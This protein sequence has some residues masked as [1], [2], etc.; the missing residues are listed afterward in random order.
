ME[1]RG[2]HYN[3]TFLKSVILRLDY[4][5][6]AVLQTDQETPFTQDMKVERYPDVTSNAATQ[7]SF[8]LGAGGVNFGQQGMGWVRVHKATGTTRTLTLAPNYLAIEYG[9]PDYK[10]FDELREQIGFVLDSFRRHF[11][12]V[13][14]TRIGLRYVNEITLQEGSPLDWEGLINKDLVTSVKAAMPSGLRMARSTH[15][16]VAIKDDISVL[17]NY[18]IYNPDFPNPVARRQFV[19]DLDCYCSGV[20]EFNEAEQRIRDVNALAEN[21]FEHSIED[22]LRDKMERL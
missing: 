19:I 1:R 22:G 16:L 12:S 9:G 4:G 18:G 7:F 8:F 17:L 14:F 5:N 11:G 6:L 21:V 13:Q 3:K 10:H 2:L 15:Q 20:V